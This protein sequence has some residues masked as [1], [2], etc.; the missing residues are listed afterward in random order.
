MPKG[1]FDDCCCVDDLRAGMQAS[2]D[3]MVGM[4]ELSNSQGIGWPVKF[5]LS[6]IVAIGAFVQSYLDDFEKE[7][8]SMDSRHQA[9]AITALLRAVQP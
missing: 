2:V 1:A 6:Q 3:Q 8:G 9:A 7:H 5:L 4:V